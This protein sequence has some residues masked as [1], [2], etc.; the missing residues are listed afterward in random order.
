MIKIIIIIII[1]IIITFLFKLLCFSF[2]EYL[3]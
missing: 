2:M 3:S 1:I